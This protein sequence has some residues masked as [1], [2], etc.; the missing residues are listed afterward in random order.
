MIFVGFGFQIEEGRDV[1]ALGIDG[2]GECPGCVVSQ[3]YPIVVALANGQ[4][5]FLF[6]YFDIQKHPI[7]YKLSILLLSISQAFIYLQ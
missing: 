6:L 5:K 2:L 7:Y 1:G 4:F 3:P